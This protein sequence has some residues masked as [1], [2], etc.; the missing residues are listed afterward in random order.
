M[1]TR[2]SLTI[3]CS[4]PARPAEF[5]ALALG[6]TKKPAPEG[7]GS[8]DE[9]FAHHDVPEDEWD[10]GAYLCDP[11]GVGP[12]LSILKV[13]EAKVV[14]NRLHLDIQAGGGR[15]TPWEVRWPRVV[16]AVGRLTAAG[17]T[18]VREDELRG[19]PDHVL[20]ADPEGN[21]FCLV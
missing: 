5:W 1:A 11:D 9:W 12:D 7:F 14:K 10:D 20:M 6:Y 19:K 18:V 15:G 3:D 17:A 21:E 2:R 4:H 8:W 13:P 16:E